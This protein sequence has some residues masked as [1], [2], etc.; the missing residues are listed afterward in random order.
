MR[1]RNKRKLR[2]NMDR[3]RK[4]LRALAA[5]VILHERI[6]TTAARAKIAKSAVEKL[7]TR[8]KTPGVN[9]I[10]ILRRDLPV[11]AVKKVMEVLS[12]RFSSR[13]GGYT[14]LI[15]VGKFKDGTSKVLLELVK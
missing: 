7:I 12:P 3:R 15:H 9:T 6:Q 11:N 1:H 13:P 14:R 4:E 5:S 8:G 10:R 2:G